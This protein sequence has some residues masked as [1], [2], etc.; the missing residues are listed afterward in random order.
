MIGAEGKP[1]RQQPADGQSTRSSAAHR[2]AVLAPKQQ[3]R[4]C[5]LTTLSPL[6]PLVEDV[7]SRPLYR[8]AVARRN[9]LDDVSGAPVELPNLPRRDTHMRGVC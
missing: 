6:S 3:G 8:I 7:G 5:S 1:P 2:E 4:G 9:D